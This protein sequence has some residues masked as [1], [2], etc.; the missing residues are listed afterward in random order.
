MVGGLSRSLL[1]ELP[2]PAPAPTPP[3]AGAHAGNPTNDPWNNVFPSVRN[4][5]NDDDYEYPGIDYFME[6]RMTLAASVRG[7][8]AEAE[9]RG[10]AAAAVPA[11]APGEHPADP[12]DMGMRDMQ[13]GGIYR[14]WDCMHELWGRICSGCGRVYTG[15]QPEDE[16]EDNSDDDYSLG[17]RV[18]ELEDLEFDLTDEED[19]WG[20]H[21]PFEDDEDDHGDPYAALYE[22][23]HRLEPVPLNRHEELEWLRALVPVGRGAGGRV[24]NGQ[25]IE[26]LRALRDG[27][28]DGDEDDEV[29]FDEPGDDGE[30]FHFHLLFYA[31][32]WVQIRT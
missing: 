31:N 4:T 32:Q 24:R 8:M 3:T 30:P 11:A 15:H 28:E 23:V 22:E 10:R 19:G 5:R 6:E 12:N 16:D 2:V 21:H 29:I 7:A 20:N 17:A 27:D 26:A 18:R 1:V 13:D 14:C 25:I 9:R